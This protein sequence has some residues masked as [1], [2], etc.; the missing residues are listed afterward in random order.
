MRPGLLLVN[1]GSPASPQTADV[2]QYLTRSL[3]DPN[4]TTLPPALWQP[5]LRGLILPLRTWHSAACYR[6]SWLAAGSPLVIRSRQIRDLVQANLP[7]WKVSL[8][9]TYGEPAI[10][11]TLKHM[12][13]AGCPQVIV[14][15]LFPQYTQRTHQ[16]ILTQAEASDVP[17]TFIKHFYDEPDYLQLLADQVQASYDQHNYDRV[18]FSYHSIPT[19]MVRHG[20]PYLQECLATTKAVLQRLP[21]LPAERVSTAF[22]SNFGPLPWLKPAL[23]TELMTLVEKG[24]RNVLIVTPSVVV[25][26]LATIEEDHIQNYQ[27][28]RASGGN[29]FDLVPPMNDN[30]RFSQF[31]ADLA[32][33]W[34]AAQ[35]HDA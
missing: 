26:C 4:I 35:I 28:F 25:D 12:A 5:L 13:A 19:A 21:D 34:W 20:D 30:P 18:I 27:T 6:D 32:T 7:H 1:T 31:L 29:R 9:M 8:A 10:G 24:Q 23:K 22:Q 2:K 11:Q 3:S 15:P 33:R 14:L 17:I 16:S